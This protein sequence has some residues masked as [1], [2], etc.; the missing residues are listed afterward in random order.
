MANI[1]LRILVLDYSELNLLLFF[2][3]F[4][5]L[6]G[7]SCLEDV[8][9]GKQQSPYFF[10]TSSPRQALLIVDKSVVCDCKVEDVALLLISAFFCFNICYTPG[11]H[12]F[13]AFLGCIFLGS[14]AKVPA[15]VKH[16]LAA[17]G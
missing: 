16:L 12:N 4:V 7:S 13:F 14:K 5:L 11:C 9:R 8:I 10:I 2:F 15:S 1:V 17:L 6:Q 3:V